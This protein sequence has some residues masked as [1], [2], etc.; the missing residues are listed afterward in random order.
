MSKNIKYITDVYE[1]VSEFFMCGN[2]IMNK[3]NL[4]QNSYLYD[5]KIDEL[6][7]ANKDLKNKLLFKYLYSFPRSQFM[8]VKYVLNSSSLTGS[9]RLVAATIAGMYNQKLGYSYPNQSHISDICG[10]SVRAVNT[11]IERMKASGEWLVTAHKTSPYEK[12][13]SNR[14]Y[15]LPPAGYGLLSQILANYPKELKKISEIKPFTKLS[16]KNAISQ[17]AA[18]KT[19]EKQLNRNDTQNYKDT[20]PDLWIGKKQNMLSQPLSQTVNY[21]DLP[22]YITFHTEGKTKKLNL[23]KT[24]Y[25]RFVK[26]FSNDWDDEYG[27][28][29]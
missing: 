29:F 4:N 17:M 7:D 25:K 28:R 18:F 21:I 26:I 20:L 10:M 6:L 24:K 2:R 5:K 27:Q 23:N 9:D 1:N 3:T 13:I 12:S 19:L 8:A 15:L 11:S 22:Q 16:N 14:Y